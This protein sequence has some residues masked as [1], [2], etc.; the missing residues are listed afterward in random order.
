LVF[1][2]FSTVHIVLTVHVEPVMYVVGMTLPLLQVTV[3]LISVA[4]YC[5]RGPTTVYPQAVH[6]VGVMVAMS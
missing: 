6:A 3:V 4:M 2:Y 5:G 1:P